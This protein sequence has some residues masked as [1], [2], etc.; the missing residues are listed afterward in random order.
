M[1]LKTEVGLDN[2]WGLDHGTWSVLKRFYPNAD[3]P[4]IQLSLDYYREPQYHYELARELQALRNKGI[5]IIGSGNMVHNL[6]ALDWGRTNT[7]YDWAIEA[8]EKFK[9]LIML[10][11]H[12]QL[13]GYKKLGSAVQ[14]AVP[15][16]EH[17]LPMLYA[18]ALKNEKDEISFFNDKPVMGSLTMT[19]LLI[20]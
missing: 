13:T 19:S 4:V 1:I 15:T 7:G 14:M 5:L 10:N 6:R 16:P 3:I 8:N 9:Q 18:L 17:F 20:G 12:Q 11:D 2:N